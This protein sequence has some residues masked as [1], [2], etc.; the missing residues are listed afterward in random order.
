MVYYTVY[1]P[2]YFGH[3]INHTGIIILTDEQGGTLY[4]VLGN[5][6]QGMSLEMKRG[7]PLQLLET[8]VPGTDKIVG[9]VLVENLSRL[10]EICWSIP[11]PGP[12]MT[13]KVGSPKR[14]TV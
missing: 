12:Q 11:P 7:G 5:I 3:D 13:T 1:T 9:R 2:E 6:L 14:S 10:E 8:F 4:H